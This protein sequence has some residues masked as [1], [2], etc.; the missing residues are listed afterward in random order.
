M[1]DWASLHIWPR[2]RREFLS[3]YSDALFCV[4]FPGVLC[5]CVLGPGR[6]EIR[7]AMGTFMSVCDSPTQGSDQ[8][9]SLQSKNWGSHRL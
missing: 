8:V 2:K 5:L 7:D 9:L 3:H 4:N 1:G 6:V